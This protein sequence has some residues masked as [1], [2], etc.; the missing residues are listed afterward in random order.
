MKKLYIYITVCFLSLNYSFSQSKEDIKIYTKIHSRDNS[1]MGNLR[2]KTIKKYPN[3]PIV[4]LY[5]L[6][7]SDDYQ[8]FGPEYIKRKY[9][10][11]RY[12]KLS[13]FTDSL[14]NIKSD[15]HFLKQRRNEIIN[16]KTILEGRKDQEEF[17]KYTK[18]IRKKGWT[19]YYEKLEE[20]LNEMYTDSVEFNELIGNLKIRFEELN[21]KSFLETNFSK[22][23]KNSK[24]SKRSKKSKKS[25]SSNNST[26]EL[27]KKNFVFSYDFGKYLYAFI[28]TKNNVD[29]IETVLN[30]FSSFPITV[31]FEKNRIE[32]NSSSTSFINR[33]FNNFQ[34]KKD[35]EKLYYEISEG[36]NTIDNTINNVFKILNVSGSYFND[37]ETSEVVKILRTN[38]YK[39]PYIDLMD[40]KFKV[41][42]LLFKGEN[43]HHNIK[44]I[45]QNVFQFSHNYNWYN[46]SSDFSFYDLKEQF[47]EKDINTMK[48]IYRYESGVRDMNGREEY[49]YVM[50]DHNEKI[51]NPTPK[52]CLSSTHKKTIIKTQLN[53]DNGSNPIYRS[54]ISFDLTSSSSC[55]Y[56]WNILY[57]DRYGGGGQAQF[58]TTSDF[59]QKDERIE[60]ELWDFNTNRYM[61]P[62]FVKAVY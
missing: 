1:V 28:K 2:E 25:K 34:R 51:N 13:D 40:M 7:E 19:N 22:N 27:N 14:K 58:R 37:V 57:V 24:K 50:R 15:L 3:N 16:L 23:P 10:R 8:S 43:Y 4:K 17:E 61:S 18:K 47:T 53:T 11:L 21:N 38:D 31:E 33:I 59:S 26:V 39:S 30:E 41:H 6:E 42:S 5:K 52:N 20:N 45:Y 36:E 56:T 60:I 44:Q 54:F 32:F 46:K 9:E 29:L 49:S 62:V 35:G 48:E 12:F 55:S